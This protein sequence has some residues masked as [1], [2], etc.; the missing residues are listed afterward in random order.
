MVVWYSHIVKHFSL[1]VV[2]HTVKSFSVLSEAKA[3][4]FWNSLGFSMFQQML[5]I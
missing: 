4:V 1:F 2:I 3:D 5:A